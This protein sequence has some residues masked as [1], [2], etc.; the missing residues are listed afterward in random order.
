MMGVTAVTLTVTLIIVQSAYATI[1]TIVLLG[2]LPLLLET[3]FVMMRLTMLSAIMMAEIAVSTSTLITVLI[4][5]VIFMKIVLLDLFRM[6]LVMVFVMMRLTI[7]TANMMEETVAD[8][9]STLI[10]VLTVDA[11]SMQL[12]LLGLIP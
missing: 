3:V 6:W 7:S 8:T 2:L 10:F 4:V 9:M 5:N 1:K 11:F 12:V